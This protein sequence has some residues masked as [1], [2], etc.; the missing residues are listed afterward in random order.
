MDVW[1]TV[2]KDMQDRRQLGLYRYNKPVVADDANEDWLQH[3]YE[4]ALDMTV[5]LRAEIERRKKPSPSFQ[6]IT[7][8]TKPIPAPF[9]PT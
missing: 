1:E 4:E 8:D 9:G 7:L 5:Y 6:E 2:I 3:A